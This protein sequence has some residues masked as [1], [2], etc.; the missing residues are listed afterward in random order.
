MRG[1]ASRACNVRVT[2]VTRSRGRCAW[3]RPDTYTCMRCN[4]RTRQTGYPRGSSTPTPAR[5]TD[6]NTKRGAPARI[7]RTGTPS[8]SRPSLPLTPFPPTLILTSAF[9]FSA[10]CPFFSPLPLA[11]LPSAPSRQHDGDMRD[12][13]TALTAEVTHPS[14]RRC[15]PMDSWKTDWDF[16]EA[17]HRDLS[18]P[19]SSCR[20]K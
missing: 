18:A 15:L 12:H 2:C 3:T 13:Q 6:S 4:C 17:I 14:T 16:L 20:A 10:P 5:D 9:L 8:S 11:P 19:F 7:V 1:A